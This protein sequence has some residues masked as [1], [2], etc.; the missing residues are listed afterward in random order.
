[1]A[2]GVIGLGNMG[3][4][5]ARN[6][7]RAGSSLAVWDASEKAIKSFRP[8]AEVLTPGEMSESCS[9]IFFVVP[10]SGEI[11]AL[12]TG[13]DGILAHARKGLVLYDLTTSD[14]VYTNK[15]ARRAAKKGVAYLD[16]GMSGGAAGAEAGTLTLMIGGDKKAFS[17]TRKH[18][19][20]IAD[21]LFY[22]GGSGAGHTMKLIHNMV[23]HTNFLA[24]SEAG[25]LADRAGIDLADM[26][27][28]FNAGNARNYA[29]EVRFPNH[30]LSEKWDAN[31]R[32][33]NLHK[34]L[35]MVVALAKSLKADVPLGEDVLKFLRKAM[36]R[37][38][39]DEDY[40]LLYRDYNKIGGRKG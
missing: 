11:D 16:A 7:A 29:S 13:K 24:V 5:I 27:Q 20:L 15:L 10:G 26:I 25:H 6:I 23:C 35:N 18:L 8:K 36:K 3:A 40:S 1:Q 22:L 19:K 14:P 33:Y 31:S 17:R 30:I 38:M 12:L 34:D 4:G 9:V 21:K 39:Q 2:I 28:V 37:G 32:V